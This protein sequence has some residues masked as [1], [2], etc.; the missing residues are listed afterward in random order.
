MKDDLIR[1]IVVV[2][3]F[4]G[5]DQRGRPKLASIPGSGDKSDHACPSDI[6]PQSSKRT[7]KACQTDVITCTCRRLGYR[8]LRRKWRAICDTSKAARD[9]ISRVSLRTSTARALGWTHLMRLINLNSVPPSG[10]SVSDDKT[11]VTVCVPGGRPVAIVVNLRP[12]RQLAIAVDI[13][14]DAVRTCQCSDLRCPTTH[15]LS[16][17]PLSGH[18]P[19]NRCCPTQT[20]CSAGC[21]T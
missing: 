2:G 18:R 6:Q 20:S 11:H 7:R 13:F 5:R 16:P 3:S 14:S 21:I 12:N 9:K 8:A 4:R 15:P 19:S 1:Y 10:S 17:C